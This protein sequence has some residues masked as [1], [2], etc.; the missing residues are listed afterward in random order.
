M[1]KKRGEGNVERGEG[2]LRRGLRRDLA[3]GRGGC[4]AARGA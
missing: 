4:D 1:E 3:R 2:T